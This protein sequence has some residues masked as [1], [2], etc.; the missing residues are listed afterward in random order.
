MNGK[1]NKN[2]AIRISMFVGILLATH[3][4]LLLSC[5][6]GDGKGPTP[7]ETATPTNTPTQT[8]TQTP[9]PTPTPKCNC[10]PAGYSCPCDPNNAKVGMCNGSNSCNT[11]CAS[12]RAGNC[13]WCKKASAPSCTKKICSSCCGSGVI[14]NNTCGSWCSNGGA[15][16]DCE[17][18]YCY[19]HSWGCGFAFQGCSTASDICP[20]P[21]FCSTASF[22]QAQLPCYDPAV[23][24]PGGCKWRCGGYYCSRSGPPCA[25]YCSNNECPDPGEPIGGGTLAGCFCDCSAYWGWE[26][27]KLFGY[28]DWAGHSYPKHT[29]VYCP[30]E[31]SE[32]RGCGP[33]SNHTCPHP[34]IL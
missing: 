19:N 17:K 10:V 14:L 33:G 13:K 16:P 30:R 23:Q 31:S 9:T 7:T 15:P 4:L 32:K 28:T 3:F 2:L 34:G 22:S 12:Q 6:A 20:S 26:V 8:P 11:C 5:L 29:C 24:H 27:C 21:S 25:D 18:Q 1:Q